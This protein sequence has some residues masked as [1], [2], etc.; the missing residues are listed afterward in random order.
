MKNKVESMV[1][2]K[3]RSLSVMMPTSKLTAL[4]LS[5]SVSILQPR[6]CPR[7]KA[8][9]GPAAAAR[10]GGWTAPRTDPKRLRPAAS[11]ED[12]ARPTAA[13]ST[14]P[15]SLRKTSTTTR[16]S[17]ADDSNS[18]G[19][20]G[21]DI[22]FSRSRPPPP[23]SV[24]SVTFQWK[25]KT[26][27]KQPNTHTHT[28]TRARARSLFAGFLSFYFDCPNIKG[29]AR[30]HP[31]W[32]YRWRL[33]LWVLHSFAPPPL[34]FPPPPPPLSSTCHQLKP[35]PSRLRPQRNYFLLLHQT[36][37]NQHTR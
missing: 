35:T 13:E 2:T 33:F 11:D 22:G 19:N 36:K 26:A 27:K 5:L 6:N 7:A 3:G 29:G 4:S 34:F 21:T 37:L 9:A 16:P 8:P 32:R 15:P 28:Y 23:P 10:A 31:R 12:G 24:H 30:F 1:V 18:E 14:T 20:T 17:K 25:K